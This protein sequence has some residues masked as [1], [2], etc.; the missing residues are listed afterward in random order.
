MVKW[1][2]PLTSSALN[3]PS[4]VGSSLAQGTNDI[5]K[6][7][8]F[9]SQVVRYFSLDPFFLPHLIIEQAENE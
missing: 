8:K 4:A 3:R 5:V 2:R 1:L 7:S 6:L 9:C